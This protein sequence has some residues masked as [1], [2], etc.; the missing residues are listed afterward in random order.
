[1]TC[2][3]CRSPP[4]RLFQHTS[5]KATWNLN[6]AE[7]TNH[8]LRILLLNKAPWLYSALISRS[9]HPLLRHDRIVTGFGAGKFQQNL[10]LTTSSP[11]RKVNF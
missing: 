5:A 10:L 8:T 4:A 11:F 1:M 6:P 2:I 9:S 3:L 7:F